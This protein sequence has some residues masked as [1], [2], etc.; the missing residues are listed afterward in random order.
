MNNMLCHIAVCI[1][2]CMTASAVAAS[3]Q[4]ADFVRVAFEQ[5]R[6]R[7]ERDDKGTLDEFVAEVSAASGLS[8]ATSRD[9]LVSLLGDLKTHCKKST[10]LGERLFALH[11]AHFSEREAKAYLGRVVD[12]AGDL[13]KKKRT[14][15]WN[16]SSPKRRAK[17]S[18]SSSKP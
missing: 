6:D 5:L 13:L 8:A 12:M 7:L 14:L 10:A 9:S 17:A 15:G 2:F 16:R 4:E 11:G 3:A 18:C 1:F